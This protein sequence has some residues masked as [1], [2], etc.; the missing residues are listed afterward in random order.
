MINSRKTSLLVMVAG[1]MM[2]LMSSCNQPAANTDQMSDAVKV[3]AQIFTVDSHTDTPLWLLRGDYDLSQRHDATTHGSKVDLPRMTEGGLDA[4]FFAVFL[5]QEARTPEG[6]QHAIDL[7]IRIFDSIDAHL[8]RVPE[9]AAI[10]T[11]PDEALRL[12][13]EGEKAIFLGIE[14]GYAI[15]NDLAQIGNFYNRGAR[16]ITLCHTRN[17]DI[18]D[19]S[20]DS[21]EHHGLS[22]FGRQVVSEMNRQGMMIDV[23]HIS[24]S[25][26]YD[27]LQVSLQP[28]IASHSS[29]RAICDHP[30]NMSDDMLL[31][32]A[33]NGG[34]AQVCILSDYVKTMPPNAQRDSAQSALREKYNNFDGLS[35]E[36]MIQAR[37]EWHA[38]NKNFPPNLATLSDYA[39]H[40]DHVVSVAGID[41]V[42]IGT[43]F[44]GGGGVTGC[45]D[46]SEMHNI[47]A[48]LLRRGY[49][50]EEIEKIWGGNLMRV[51]RQVQAA[52]AV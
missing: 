52:R 21:T 42:G 20:T 6:N 10:A 2:L 50:A 39:D 49:S 26:F 48:E 32:L 23:S 7:A 30:R 3:Q 15:G 8:Q 51:M 35:E 43:D 13:N 12:K 19:S 29:A 5:G 41:H 17:N 33:K 25:S 22:D 31:K 27:V 46:A 18:C 45:F 44:D 1:A 9:L 37:S 36:L 11:S 38:V 34:V 4:V 16:Y 14:N 24:D 47:T 28:V 40:I